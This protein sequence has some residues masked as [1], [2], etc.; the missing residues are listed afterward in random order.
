MEKKIF[1]I[2]LFAVGL[3]LAGCTK[4][5]CTD[6]TAKN[7]DESAKK[8]DGSCI[9]EPVSV[10]DLLIGL[11]KCTRKSWYA[12]DVEYDT[13]LEIHPIRV[14]DKIL[15]V[16]DNSIDLSFYITYTENGSIKDT[17]IPNVPGYMHNGYAPSIWGSLREDSLHFDYTLNTGEHYVY[18]GFKI[19]Q[20]PIEFD[21]PDYRDAWVGL[22]D[23][24][25]KNF[26]WLPDTGSVSGPY[27]TTLEVSLTEN[28]S[29]LKI[30][31][32]GSVQYQN[33]VY[34]V[35]TNGVLRSPSWRDDPYPGDDK[36][37][38]FVGDSLYYYV[39]VR[40]VGAGTKSRFYCK[41][42]Q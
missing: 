3:L 23:G 14:S 5:G 13:E 30:I 38:S 15:R 1:V 17:V 29:V 8:D 6:P 2:I 26:S 25:K 37:G 27:N 11:Y 7:Y 42:R 35:N 10:H 32:V 39:G 34:Y 20:F 36:G 28:D 9:Y 4:R 24:T 21:T 18:D 16:S 40:S 31:E 41:K 12:Q 19:Q 33:A 22:Y